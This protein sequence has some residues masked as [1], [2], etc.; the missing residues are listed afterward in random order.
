MPP[1]PQMLSPPKCYP[2]ECRP[3]P[4]QGAS[5]ILGLCG[6]TSIFI[7]EK[8]VRTSSVAANL[9]KERKKEEEKKGVQDRRSRLFTADKDYS[10][11]LF[12]DIWNRCSVRAHSDMA[13]I[14]SPF[15][16]SQRTSDEMLCFNAA[17]SF[18]FERAV[19]MLACACSTRMDTCP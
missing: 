8:A 3:L 14:V 1:P 16:F 2:H 15:P 9:E 10:Y 4:V 11:R 7:P 13:H 19:R 5:E 18:F 17:K 6:Q 12:C